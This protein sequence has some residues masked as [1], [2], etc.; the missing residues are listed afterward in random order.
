MWATT[1]ISAVKGGELRKSRWDREEGGAL[2]ASWDRPWN[3]GGPQG[4]FWSVGVGM[5]GR[6]LPSLGQADTWVTSCY[7][8]L[9][10]HRGSAPLFY[11]QKVSPAIHSDPSCCHVK[12]AVCYGFGGYIIPPLSTFCYV[13]VLLFFF[14]FSSDWSIPIFSLF[15]WRSESVC[16]CLFFPLSLG[17]W[18]LKKVSL[19]AD[20][21]NTEENG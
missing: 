6:T 9:Q 8:T 10:P 15:A 18:D 14:L 12:L 2:F 16:D 4:A 21:G 19:F 7:E 20:A 3:Q 17:S 13:L 5:G 11:H 1:G